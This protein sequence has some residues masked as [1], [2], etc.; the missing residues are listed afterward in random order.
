MRVKNV[1]GANIIV[2]S[3]SEHSEKTRD[4]DAD[5]TS[6]VQGSGSDTIS[7]L[8]VP[9]VSNGDEAFRLINPWRMSV[10]IPRGLLQLVSSGIG[11][12]LML[13]VMT[14][15]IGYLFAVLVG[16]LIGE[17]VFGRFGFAPVASRRKVGT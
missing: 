10:D 15:N 3:T 4:A 5:S 11:Y 9:L 14:G 2:Q 1:A 8:S 17:V 13:A 6:L 16:V 12:L 7:T